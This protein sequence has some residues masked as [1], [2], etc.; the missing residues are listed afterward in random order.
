MIKYWTKN[1]CLLFAERKLNLSI[2]LELHKKTHIRPLVV[3]VTC[4]YNSFW[5]V[6]LVTDVGEGDVK[7]TFCIHIDHGQYSIGHHKMIPV[8]MYL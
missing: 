8:I 6:G 7:I 1:Q 3:Y 5:W 4:I 2:F